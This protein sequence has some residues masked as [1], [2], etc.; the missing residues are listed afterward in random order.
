MI[1]QKNY[2]TEYLKREDQYLAYRTLQEENTNK[3]VREARDKDRALAQGGNGVPIPDTTAAA[4][5]DE[6]M[7]DAGDEP[8]GA[9]IIVI[10]PG[11]QYLR[12]GF[13]NDALPKTVPMVIARRSKESE[14]EA[15]GGEPQPK[16]VKIDDEI[17][18]EPDKFWGEEWGSMYKEWSADLKVEMRN[19][20]IRLM[21]N[22]KELVINYNKRRVPEMISE[23]NDPDRIEWT[24]ISPKNPPEFVTGAAALRIPEKSNPRYKLYWPIQDGWFNEKAYRQKNL[25]YTDYFKIIEEAIKVELGLPKREWSQYSCVFILPDL[26]EKM[27][28]I[29]ILD[30]FLRVFGFRRF[31]FMQESLASSFGAGY[32]ISC[33]VDVGA[34]KTSICCVEDGLCVEDS[35]MNLK[36]G[37]YDV[38]E[39]FM[40]MMLQDYFPYSDINLKR[41]H[42]WLLAEELKQKYCHLNAA[43]IAVGQ[44]DFLLRAAGQD[45]QK[46]QFRTYDE[47]YL[48]PYVSFPRVPRT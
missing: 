10:H 45:T 32:S 35:R 20:R 40:K 1:N 36:Y 19:N 27:P 43:D 17:P 24:E 34:Q 12:I 13:A 33:V 7:E 48:A 16:R 3:L 31:C 6:E 38:T 47:V 25:L 41:R 30:E 21:P 4:D 46:F 42:D 37:G 18:D 11:S 2:Y 44:H 22:S 26:Y 9:K 14:S 28:V 8:H 23:H 5:E 29:G 39:A 15:N